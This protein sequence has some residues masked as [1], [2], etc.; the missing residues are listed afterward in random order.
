MRDR[1]TERPL[2]GHLLIDVDPLMVA[3]GVREQIDVLL[4]DP[5][6]IAGA[7]IDL[8]RKIFQLI[9][10]HF[11]RHRNLLSVGGP[12]SVVRPP[13]SARGAL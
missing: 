3:G 13:L 8:A 9:H 12:G 7:E 10:A 1:L 2:L 4:L 6:P 11:C 5:V